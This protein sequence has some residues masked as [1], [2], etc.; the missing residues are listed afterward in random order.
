MAMLDICFD[1][2][3]NEGIVRW[4]IYPKLFEVMKS[5]GY[6]FGI[7]S[8]KNRFANAVHK[9]IFYNWSYD[10]MLQNNSEVMLVSFFWGEMEG[11]E[12][13]LKYV[14]EIKLLR[15][16]EVE[17]CLIGRT[18]YAGVVVCGF[19]DETRACAA[20]LGVFLFET[21]DYWSY[22]GGALDVFPP[23]KVGKW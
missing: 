9:K 12:Y 23:S 3:T 21:D 17:N 6:N 8:F 18:I 22:H 11:S 19:D 14:E 7:V 15:E 1:L 5:C 2:K 20:D 4:V 13:L 16:N 10:F